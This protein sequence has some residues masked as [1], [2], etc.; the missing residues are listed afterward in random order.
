MKDYNKLIKNLK[1]DFSNFNKLKIAIL[2]DS[3]TQFLSNAIKAAGIERQLNFDIYEGD[4]N[5]A[6]PIISDSD[7]GL[8]KYN[9][10]III[11]FF[12]SQK[13]LNRYSSL[14]N[15]DE[16]RSF[17]DHEIGTLKNLVQKIQS[18]LKSKIIFYNFLEINDYVFG[19][20]G[21]K[22][23]YSF[24]YQIKRLNLDLMNMA[25]QNPDLYLLDLNS[26]N[27]NFGN[28]NFFKS[29][30][31]INSDV[32][33]SLDALPTIA[34]QTSD[35]I[36]AFVGKFKKCLIL[37]LDN[38]IWGGVIGDDG[39][40]NIQLGDLGIGKAFVE[41][42]KWIKKLKNRGVIV[43]VCSKNTEHIAKD[44]FNNHPE[45]ILRLDDIT[46]FLA[47]W[48][49]K[50]DNINTIQKSLNIGMDSMVFLDDNPFERNLVKQ[51]IPEITVPELP[52]DPADYLNYLYKLNL[53]EITSF[54]KEDLERTNKYQIEIQRSSAQLSYDSKEAYLSSLKM[55]SVV[56]Y[57]NEYNTPRVAQLSQRS[58]QFNLRTIRYGESEIKSISSSDEYLPFVFSLD[59]IF[60]SHGLIS[61]V[62][63][64]KIN[65]DSL[66]IESWFM[67]CRVLQRTMEEF[68]INTIVNIAKDR[69]YKY[70]YGEYIKTPKNA[71]VQD[72]LSSLGFVEDN[73]KWEY[74]ICSHS[75]QNTYITINNKS[76]YLKN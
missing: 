33:I 23:E 39:I 25:V 10:D 38:T 70:I 73:D 47:N 18:N 21:L 76:L 16:L 1:I 20:F 66:F 19:N 27:N 42:Q 68:T 17:S 5:Q 69:G 34:Y 59:D 12:S 2:G 49:S 30:L 56:D 6:I 22:L 55:E 58:N 63:L 32:V 29:S 51:H 74:D 37:D 40:E 44:P 46:I 24:I 28:D 64:K 67:S 4:Y 7:S 41:L 15:I 9:P 57:F 52:D 11:I 62:I 13:L 50:V 8:Y 60:G 71:I 26:I 3:A 35:I 65:T 75:N 45:M 48:E 36:Q 54:S 31:Y 53:F 14:T 72:L 61:V 43:C